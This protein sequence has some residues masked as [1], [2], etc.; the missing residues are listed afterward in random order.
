MPTCSRMRALPGTAIVSRQPFTA[1]A[2]DSCLVGPASNSC[3][4]S[5]IS[6][7]SSFSDTFTFAFLRAWI[8]A[9]Y[10]ASLLSS[11]FDSFDPYLQRRQALPIRL[12]LAR[13]DTIGRNNTT[14]MIATVALVSVESFGMFEL[15]Y[16]E[17]PINR[18]CLG[19]SLEAKILEQRI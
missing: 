7:S 11:R 10:L 17:L 18:S 15:D 8:S 3:L 4:L 19:V 14:M 5:P 16:W 9:L 12:P 2:V 6:R 13:R 1:S